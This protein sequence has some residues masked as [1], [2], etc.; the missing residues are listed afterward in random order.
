VRDTSRAV[1]LLSR[2]ELP[3][4]PERLAK[5]LEDG[6]RVFVSRTQPMVTVRG[7]NVRALEA[8]SIDLSNARVDFLRRPPRPR[9]G[10]IT[11]A[12]S[13]AEFSVIAEPL[14]I[15][16]AQIGFQ[17]QASNVEFAQATQP[18]DKLLL[19]LHRAVSGN[20]RIEAAQV[21]LEKLISRAAGKLAQ[22]QGVTIDDVKLALTQPQPRILN[23]NII[24][25]ARK[26][27]F[28][29]VLNLSGTI[30]IDEELVATV[31]DLKCTGDGPIATLACAAI[32]PQFRRVE[33]R[34]FPLSA[35][36]LGEVQLHDVALDFVN[37]RVVI[38]AKFGERSQ[39]A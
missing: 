17:L 14:S 39:R 1:F 26:L 7:D 11:P 21:E 36:P 2:S 19:L 30:A 25:A 13:A 33:Q 24:V 12:L 16:D 34:A 38:A 6:L 20:V 23:A 22:K 18:D 5:A 27:L 35:L 3:E 32:T 31:S 15:L 4:Q 10:D 28:R 29:P 8:I 37:D 9:L